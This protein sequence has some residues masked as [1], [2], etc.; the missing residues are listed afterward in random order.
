MMVWTAPSWPSSESQERMAVVLAPADV[1]AF[2]ALADGEN[3]ESAIV[4]TVTD[5]N[6]LRM[7]WNGKIICDI[8]R[9]FLNSNGMRRRQ[10]ASVFPLQSGP[11]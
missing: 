6:R 1:E 2:R 7:H 4:A 8:S 5:T 10:P 11:R 9:D 3:L